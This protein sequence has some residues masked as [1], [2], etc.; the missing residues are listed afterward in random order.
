MDTG[1]FI[2]VGR[3]LLHGD[4]V[5]RPGAKADKCRVVCPYRGDEAS[6]SQAARM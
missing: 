4:D 3:T 5:E 6:R 1:Y 2:R